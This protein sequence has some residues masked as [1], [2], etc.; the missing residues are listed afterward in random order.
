MEAEYE[1]LLYHREVRQLSRGQALKWA[2][3]LRT[4]ISLFLKEKKTHS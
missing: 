4:E 1:V 3:E 2:F